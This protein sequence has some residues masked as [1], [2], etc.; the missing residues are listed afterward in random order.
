M[1][2]SNIV[3]LVPF[4][5][6]STRSNHMTKAYA[7]KNKI[8]ISAKDL[9]VTFVI[10]LMIFIHILMRFT[11]QE[12]TLNEVLVWE[13]NFMV[14]CLI[15]IATEF[16]SAWQTWILWTENC[17]KGATYWIYKNN[18][19]IFYSRNIYE[20]FLNTMFWYLGLISDMQRWEVW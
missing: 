20:V 4:P 10:N 9:I 5:I 7:C 12:I 16:F 11:N 18:N 8:I 2:Y 3:F 17:S 13:H 15:S 1:L 6:T 14:R 19:N